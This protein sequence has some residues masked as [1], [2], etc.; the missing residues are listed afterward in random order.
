MAS[1]KFKGIVKW[2]GLKLQGPQNLC[3]LM[4]QQVFAVHLCFYTLKLRCCN[5]VKNKTSQQIR[6]IDDFSTLSKY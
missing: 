2:R 4:F 1:I 3:G 5:F 6:V